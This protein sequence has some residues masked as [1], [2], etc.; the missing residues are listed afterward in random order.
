MATETP[1]DDLNPDV[2]LDNN[3]ISDT[4]DLDIDSQLGSAEPP[5]DGEPSPSDDFNVEDMPDDTD[6]NAGAGSPPAGG[7]PPPSSVPPSSVPPSPGLT[8]EQIST[9]VN[10]YI[11]QRRQNNASRQR[12]LEEET[13]K[14]QAEL[15]RQQQLQQRQQQ[16]PAPPASTP[17]LP[18]SQQD[19]ARYAY[20][21]QLCRFMQPAQALELVNQQ[22]EYYEARFKKQFDNAM[23]Q[24]QP[25]F[26]RQI[27]SA[28]Q[29]DLDNLAN[30]HVQN[31]HSAA[32]Q[33]G[34]TPEESRAVVFGHLKAYIDSG[35]TDLQDI[36][37]WFASNSATILAATILEKKKIAEEQ[38]RSNAKN[39]YLAGKNAATTIT[40][41]TKAA[42]NMVSTGQEALMKGNAAITG[43]APSGTTPPATNGL[44]QSLAAQTGLNAFSAS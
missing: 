25:L 31:F 32:S 26:D 34:I 23:K 18:P 6:T 28:Y 10:N 39:Q 13:R 38:E 1:L 21:L 14:R 2:S 12:A 16:P 3:S 33:F 42:A 19:P 5:I 43:G 40:P 15:F 22:D 27:A 8:A 36:H 24:F 30:A 37:N 29:N 4:S 7:A 17:P 20:Y 9:L 41:S 35:H 11:E 44:L